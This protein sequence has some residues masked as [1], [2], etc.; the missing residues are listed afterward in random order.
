MVM[1]DK[2]ATA[3][4]QPI[5]TGNKKRSFWRSTNFDHLPLCGLGELYHPQHRVTSI[6]TAFGSPNF[7][8]EITPLLSGCC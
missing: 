2:T 4:V 5:W 3:I 1:S 8:M 7:Q 6:A